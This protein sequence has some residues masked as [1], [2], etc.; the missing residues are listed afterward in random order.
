MPIQ[1]IIFLTKTKI[2][3][4]EINSGGKAESISIKGNTEIKCEGKESIDELIVCLYDAFNIDDFTDDKFDII[5]V[6]M[7][8]SG[9]FCAY[10]LLK[11][12]SNSLVGYK[13]FSPDNYNYHFNSKFSTTQMNNIQQNKSNTN[14]NVLLDSFKYNSIS[15]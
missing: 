8:P 13:S 3:A 11:L 14:K 9:I 1:L 12:N 5:I 6:G 7:G 15:F 2:F 10:E 4:S